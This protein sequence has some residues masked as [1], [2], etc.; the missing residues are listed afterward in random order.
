MTT[1]SPQPLAAI[2]SFHAHVYFD[3]AAQRALALSLREQIGQRF[4]VA[5]GRVRD[6]P[7]GPHPR[8]MYQVAFDVASFG[9]IVPWLMLNRQGL[10]VLVH[11]NT[12]DER[13]DHL[14]HALWMGEVLDIVD[15]QQLAADMDAEGPRPANT[16]PSI[17]P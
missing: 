10:T 14:S 11:T 2:A 12:R 1:P 8:A 3:G 7:V 16:T 4:A 13:A 17:E 15:P 5:M 9:K 6:E